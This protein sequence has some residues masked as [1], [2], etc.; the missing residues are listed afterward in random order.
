MI[1]ASLATKFLFERLASIARRFVAR[2]ARSE[3]C[4]EIS[5][6]ETRKKRF[7]LRNFV[8]RLVSRE[9]CYE[10]SVCETRVASLATNFDSRVS[11]ESSEIFGSKKRVSFLARI[12][13]SD[14]RV[15][16]SMKYIFDQSNRL[17]TLSWVSLL[18]EQSR[19]S[20]HPRPPP[21]QNQRQ[22]SGS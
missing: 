15:N 10:I 13:K 9:S 2:L 17:Y 6:C 21:H 1:L 11:R 4:Y 16:P 3:P 5:F 20:S 14:S 12:L 22:F 19:S 18:Y 8:A 7:L